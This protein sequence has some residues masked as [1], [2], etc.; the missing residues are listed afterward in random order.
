[1]A[2]FAYDFAMTI[3]YTYA[4]HK[5]NIWYLQVPMLSIK[6]MYQW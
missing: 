4:E 2:I 5:S 1:M 6:P 3:S